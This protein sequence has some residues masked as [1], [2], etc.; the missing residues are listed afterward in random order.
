MHSPVLLPATRQQAVYLFS[1]CQFPLLKSKRLGQDF[2]Q[3]YLAL[4]AAKCN[5]NHPIL[6]TQSW[7]KYCKVASLV[8]LFFL[9]KNLCAGGKGDS[10][11]KSWHTREPTLETFR[12]ES[13]L[14]DSARGCI[15]IRFGQ[16]FLGMYYLRVNP[17][18]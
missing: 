7:T 12:N 5:P 9:V 10:S 15:F 13:F 11:E 6:I 1:H 2:R 14:F 17:V 18:K 3:A 4:L 8:S 16:W